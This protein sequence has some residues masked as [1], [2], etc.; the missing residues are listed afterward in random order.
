VEGWYSGTAKDSEDTL[1]FTA[2]SGIRPSIET[3]NLDQVNE[4][5]E[6]MIIGQ[7]RF[8]AVLTMD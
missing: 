4:A 5:Y 6:H 3:F 1:N 2:L 7:A 8:R